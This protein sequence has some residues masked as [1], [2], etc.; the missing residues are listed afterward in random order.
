MELL[1]DKG[2]SGLPICSEEGHVLGIVSGYDLLAVDSVPGRMDASLDA[3]HLFPP[4]RRKVGDVLR[5]AV[6]V[7]E[8][9]SLSTAADLIVQKKVNRLV[10]VDSQGRL[11]GVLSRGDV[12]RAVINNFNIYMRSMDS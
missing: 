4:V 6:T 10:V 8:G 7:H 11:A 1:V 2:I 12:L 9:S 3:S 5:D